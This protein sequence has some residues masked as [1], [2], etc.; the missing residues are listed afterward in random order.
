MIAATHMISCDWG[1]SNFRLYLVEKASLCIRETLERPWGIATTYAMWK[2][3]KPAPDQTDY[4]RAVLAKGIA[5][6]AQKSGLDLDGVIVVASGMVSSSIGMLEIPYT[7]LPLAIHTPK[8]DHI[9]LEASNS[10]SNP[11]CIVGGLKTETDVMRG[12]EIQLLGLADVLPKNAYCILPGTHSKHITIENGT[13]NQFKTYMTGE[14]FGLMKNQSV[15]KSSMCNASPS[16]VPNTNFSKGVE[17]ALT[18]N[19]LHHFFRVRTLDLL[20]NQGHEENQ[21]YLSGLLIGTELRSLHTN[22]QPL[23]LMGD[24]KLLELYKSALDTIDSTLMVQTV[25][26]KVMD[27]AVPKAHAALIHQTNK[28]I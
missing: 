23:V 9:F 6:L 24:S 11:V 3:E 28:K 18:G 17:K 22:G 25:T 4:F 14:V 19:L 27:K 16:V 15:L 2:E 21:A 5:A 7:E 12:E 10:F 1:T 13:V 20:Q 8:L 26:A